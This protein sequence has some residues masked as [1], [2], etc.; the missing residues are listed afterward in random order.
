MISKRE[1]TT[2]RF[3]FRIWLNWSLKPKLGDARQKI[4]PAFE[5]GYGP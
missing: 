3:L 2:S 4:R 1:P 5:R